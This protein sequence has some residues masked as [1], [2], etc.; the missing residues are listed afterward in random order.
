MLARR[1]HII[2]S[3]LF[4]RQ[5]GRVARGPLPE[6][7]EIGS[8]ERAMRAYEQ[9]LE[10]SPDHAGALEALARLRE[11]SGDAHAAIVAIEALAAKAQTPEAKA[12]QWLRAARLLEGRGDRDGAIERYKLALEA[13]PAR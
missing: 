5:Y 12:E 9:V 11:I 7:P 1:V 4:Q 2:E 10:M 6:S 3:P 8:P 13:N